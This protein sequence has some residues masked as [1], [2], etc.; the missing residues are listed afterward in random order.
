M[1]KHVPKGSAVPPGYRAVWDSRERLAAAKIAP[2][3]LS[4]TKKEEFPALLLDGDDFIE[5]HI[6]GPIHRRA[7]EKLT[8]K[9]P[10]QRT[11]RVLLKS[12]KR[13]VEEVGAEVEVK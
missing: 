12:I 5:V 9:R 6:F 7:I 10:R 4:S 11:D 2:R 13:K 3:I 1:R 8:G